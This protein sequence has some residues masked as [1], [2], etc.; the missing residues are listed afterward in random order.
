MSINTIAATSSLNYWQQQAQAKTDYNLHSAAGS[1]SQILASLTASQAAA[2]TGEDGVAPVTLT[3]LLSDGSLVILKVEGNRVISEVKLDG[4]SVLQQPH[5]MG[6]GS[7][8]AAYA[9]A[10]ETGSVDAEAA[11]SASV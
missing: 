5:L 1:F 7:Q 8:S 4:T 10:A 11:F 6:L 3:K 9:G 2:H